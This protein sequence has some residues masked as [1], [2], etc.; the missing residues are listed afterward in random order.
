MKKIEIIW[1]ELLYQSIEKGNRQFTQ[2]NLAA[3]FAYSTSTVFQALRPL[4]E[5]GAVRV[6]GRN[7]TLED[8]EK[9]VY[10][11][12]SVRKL[13]SDI[14][15][16]G[17]LDIPVKEMEGLAPPSSIFGGYSAA[18]RFF[19]E[20]PADYDKLC[21][22]VR[23]LDE[24]LKRYKIGRGRPNL[25]I[26]KADDFLADYGDFTTISQTFVDIW[27]FEDWYAKE[28]TAALKRKIDEFLP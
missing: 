2:K 16:K 26:L 18:C 9:L 22:Y 20:A 21:L 15:L 24:V 6:T 27:N 19:S 1:R 11:W 8:P 17:H 14:L 4:R 25:L 23:D 7:F 12:A 28:F 10:H 3:K 5:M 13:S